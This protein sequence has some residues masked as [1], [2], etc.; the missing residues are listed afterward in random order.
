MSTKIEE[1]LAAIEARANA[2]TPGP[3]EWG[4]NRYGEKRLW[5]ADKTPV[6][7]VDDR[8]SISQSEAHVEPWSA[9]DE[10]LIAHAREDIPF[11]LTEPSKTRAA[12][13]E[14]VDRR[15]KACA[16]MPHRRDGSD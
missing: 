9:E 10:A 16:G 5:A 12:L 14:L 6:L 7:G 8:C 3:W 2:A 11:L 13:K 4:N 15:E 1:R